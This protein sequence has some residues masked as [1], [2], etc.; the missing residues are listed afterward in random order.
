MLLLFSVMLNAVSGWWLIPCLAAGV[1]YAWLLYRQPVNLS[2][3]YRYAL[4][5]LRATVVIA[6]GILLLS[7]LIKTVKYQPQKPLILI[8]Q[9]N[10]LS[11]AA[12]EPKGFDLNAFSSRLAQLKKAF[13]D[14]YDVREYHFGNAAEP[15]LSK[16]YNGRIT[17]I[18]AAIRQ[19]NEQFVNQNIG[20]LILVTDGIYNQ[21]SDPQYEA[22]NLKAGI[23]TIPL[24]DSIPRRD[25]VIS[26]INYNKTAF[27][28]NDFELEVSANA[29]MS[30]GEN[31]RL[32]VIE[33]GRQVYSSNTAISNNAFYKLIP[34]K[35]NADKKGLRKFTISLSPIGNEASLKNNTETIYVEVLDARQKV[36][37]IYNSPHPD[38]TVI[39]QAIETN[40]NYELKTIAADDLAQIKLS[41]YNLLILHQLQ[42][43]KYLQLQKFITDGRI[44]VWIMAGAQ[45]T[46]QDFNQQQKVAQLI[47]VRPDVQEVF[48]AAQ[49]GFA[50][51]TL[52]DSTLQKISKLPPL[53]APFGSYSAQST[54]N[55]LFRQKI[56]SLSTTYPLLAFN[57][58]QGVRTAVLAGE[59]LWRW[60]LSEYQTYG[61]HHAVEELL[62][63]CVQYLTANA[64]RQRFR[65][66]TTK[67]VFDES[68][69]I[70][71]NAELY[72][73]ALTLVNTPDIKLELKGPG[74]R[75][76][77]YLF[78]RTGQTYQLDAGILAPGDYIYT[79]TT[80]LGKQLLKVSGQFS[81]KAL[82]IESRQNTANHQL[83]RNLAKQ[84][85]GAMV[86]PA[87]LD[88]LPALIRK[89]ENI[90]TVINE[91]RR[92]K[93]LIDIKWAFALLLLL[94]SAEW[95]LRK[96]E[97]EV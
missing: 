74:G 46:A 34:L 10:S 13:G 92:Y 5:A 83:L 22:N 28:G 75:N 44:P 20:S 32:N 29:Y 59:G 72:N 27:L 53:L 15:G 41:D 82:D 45:T 4:A 95:F 33:E 60:G 71:L 6:I 51:F 80:Q 88:Q 3:P 63:Q 9:D 93:E 54:A 69:R 89:N 43:A 55:V 78:T 65:V 7:P 17:N 21:G 25:L 38:I 91:D 96:R 37:L 18:S 42:A 90:K 84:S 11:V 30:K 68:E 62:S 24:G 81:V 58:D 67:N 66:Y 50:N 35:L 87:N 8:A 73:D 48:A 39:K 97:G 77:S 14:D 19:L 23:Y 49:P 56:G 76:Y 52:T 31:L 79:A 70:V 94:L 40:R 12:I 86:Q 61:N 57:E 26:N 2:K 36:L 64:H 1:L 16:T 47:A 85:G